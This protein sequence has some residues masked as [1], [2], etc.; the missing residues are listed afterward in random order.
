MPARQRSA[1][2][3]Y[4]FAL[5]VI[6]L[7]VAPRGLFAPAITSDFAV[8]CLFLGTLLGAWYGGFGPSMLVSIGGLFILAAAFPDPNPE[9]DNP[10][11]LL[12]FLLIALGIAALGAGMAS[13]RRRAEAA[14]EQLQ[15]TLTS[16]GDAVLVTDAEG[17]V[18]ML[19][20]IAEQ[21]TGWTTSDA[22]GLPLE[23]VFLIVNEQ[24][25]MSVESPVTKALREGRIVGLANHTVLIA[26]DGTE[27]AIDDSAAPIR[28]S[29]GDVV[30]VV[31][32]FRDVSQRRQAEESRR[33]LAAIVESSND[34]IVGKTLEGLITSWNEAAEDLYGYT[35]EEVVGQPFSVLLPEGREDELAVFL[36][37]L[38]RGER[39]T[40]F[41]TVRRRK[42]GELIH[43]T[44]SYSPIHDAEGN[45]IGAAVIARDIGERRRAAEVLRDNEERLR[46]S[47]DAG[48]MGV[49]DW[50]IRTGALKWSENLESLHGIESG[51]FDGTFE[52]FQQLI[53]PE[54]RESVIGVIQHAI[55][56]RQPYEIEFR[57]IGTDGSLHW[58]SGKGQIYYDEDGPVRMVGVCTDVTDRKLSEETARFLARAS[59]ELASLVD[60]DSTLQKVARL[61]VP[62]FADWCAVDMVE[63]DGA[64]RRVSV[65]HV[66]P[67]KV[68]LAHQ[69]HERFPPDPDAPQGAWH[70]VRTKSSEMLSSIP[71][72]L[73]DE[74]IEDPQR[75]EIIRQLGL[76]SYI[77]VPIKIRDEV[78]GVIIFISAETGRIYDEDDLEV[79]EDLAHRAA[80][81]IENA[82]LYQ[83]VREADRRKDEFLAML[84]HELRNPLAPLRSGLELLALGTSDHGETIGLMQDQVAY[85]ARLVDDLLDVSRIVR[86]KVELRPEILALDTVVKR[87]E[88]YLRSVTDARDQV[89]IVHLPESTIW[90]NADR[91]RLGQ[92][93]ENLLNNGS[94]YTDRGG[95]IELSVTREGDSA[96][97]A[98][99]D[100][101]MGIEPDLLPRVF[102]L[103]TQSS[104]ALDRAQGGL[105]IGLTLVRKLVE[106]H[107]G[108]IAVH[109]DGPGCGSTFTVRL[110][111]V[112]TGPDDVPVPLEP[113]SA[114]TPRRVL[115]VDDNVGAARMLS[116]LISRL[117]PHEVETVH[118]GATALR[119]VGELRPNIVLLDIGLPGMD[120]YEVGR[121][122]RE[123][124]QHNGILLVA[125]TGYGQEEDR[126]RSRQAGFD[127]HLVKPV[128]VEALHALLEHPK[129]RSET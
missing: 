111:V 74:T 126:R 53:H 72:S 110:P 5:V 6:A 121:R 58:T 105:G 66:D 94:K 52:S 55:A 102:D 44:L 56:T 80:V 57:S 42:D 90:L 83:Q 1:W 7:V 76:R 69:L 50:D 34:A 19:N 116:L 59:A 89:L 70:I 29:S 114:P 48:Q 21:L 17:Y 96:V 93:I 75:R 91:V 63:S 64:L 24:S 120:G 16:I 108:S 100:N 95:R 85:L 49:W 26:K 28:D 113:E 32:V 3:R 115:V 8:G 118:D 128:A 119:R 86:G 22:A 39:I 79:A 87:T 68:E 36:D 54:D 81:A 46:L 41:E 124:T 109:S 60:L 112:E 2:N 20:P 51:A 18:T 45:P 61:S 127:E 9:D 71:Q 11:G 25:R 78:L 38:H 15:T 4:G 13:A 97:I 99:K 101:G 103:F 23:E 37:Q 92:I 33:Q 117:G 84:A 10:W 106:I 104:R 31:L 122:V 73:L 107:G 43:V 14:F 65:A 82:R 30:G 98:V 88:Q 47:L 129:L 67:D 125:V 40:H 12:F 62:F 77:G 27:M 123:D 35:A